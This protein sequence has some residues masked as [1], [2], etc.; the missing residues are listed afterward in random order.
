[1]GQFKVIL[2]KK[3][4]LV[5]ASSP[6]TR[7]LNK[8]KNVGKS[9][10]HCYNSAV[11]LALK[12]EKRGIDQY[13]EKSTWSKRD[14]GRWRDCGVMFLKLTSRWFQ[15]TCRQFF[16]SLWNTVEQFEVKTGAFYFSFEKRSQKTFS[17]EGFRKCLESKSVFCLLLY[18][19]Y[20]VCVVHLQC[21]IEEIKS[22][23]GLLLLTLIWTFVCLIRLSF[24]CITKHLMSVPSGNS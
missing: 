12:Q 10:K 22:C 24:G 6:P 13:P 5:T 8:H 16:E 20:D 15:E 23:S 9:N 17:A 1:M 7:A 19:F 2:R 3:T 21:F 14:R 11:S 18:V 4:P